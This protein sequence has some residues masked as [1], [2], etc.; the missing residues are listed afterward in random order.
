MKYYLKFIVSTFFSIILISSIAFNYQCNIVQA[1]SK[2]NN[3]SINLL[4]NNPAFTAKDFSNDFNNYAEKNATK[5]INVNTNQITTFKNSK[6]ENAN[7]VGIVLDNI[8]NKPIPNAKISTSNGYTVK[9]GSDGKFN[10]INMPNGNYNWCISANGYHRSNYDNYSINGSDGANIFTFYLDKNKD[11]YL[12]HDSLFHYETSIP[13]EEMLDISKT[14]STK[15]SISLYSMTSYPTL[16][17]YIRV[18]LSNGTIISVDRQQY[19]Y[20]VLSSEL[21]NKNYYLNKGLNDLQISNLFVAQALAANTYLEYSLKIYSNHSNCDVCSTTCCQVYD[22]TKVTQY[23]INIVSN[24][25]ENNSGSYYCPII[26]HRSKN[27]GYDYVWGAFFSS[28]GNQGTKTHS[29]QPEI[30]AKSCT[31]LVTGAGGHRYGMCQMGAAQ[32]AKSGYDY[33]SI[34]TY[35][36]TDCFIGNCRIN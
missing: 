5:I 28:C 34:I 33:N 2:N 6:L 20:T 13:P 35:Y 27:G 26:L 3:T 21:Y 11:I 17:R 24:L 23:A 8:T 32:K 9:S 12:D 19:L 1:S 14:F 36:Y 31:D 22:T 7:V 4:G 18:K 25:F 10:I 29:S 16:K 30:C 15:S